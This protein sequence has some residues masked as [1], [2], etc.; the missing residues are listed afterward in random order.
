M[1]S[2]QVNVATT[3]IDVEAEL[4]AEKLRQREQVAST[5]ADEAKPVQAVVMADG[6][7]TF[8]EMHDEV[9][10]LT[11]SQLQAAIASA[12]EAALT[13]GTADLSAQL[14]QTTE[15]LTEAKS[16]VASLNQV[17]KVLGHPNP[18]TTSVSSTNPSGLAADFVAACEAAPAVVWIDSRTGQRHVQRDMSSAR[19]I[20]LVDRNQLRADMTAYA[21]KH[22]LLQ[23]PN[24]S[25]NAPTVRT[26]IPPAFL[27]FLSM[28]MRETHEARYVYW[29]FCYEK[30]ELGKGPG[31][32]I[33]VPR[34]RWLPEAAL[35]TDRHL[36]PGTNTNAN[37]QNLTAA[38]VSIALGERGLGKD[39]TFSPVAIPEFVMAYSMLQLENAV[40]EVLGHDYQ[41][42]E[43]LSI[44]S[45]YLATTRV[46]YNDRQSV[47]TVPGNVGAGDDGTFT[48]EF[49]NNLHAYMS[50]LLIPALDDGHYVLVV[51]DVGAAQIKN[52]LS[53]RNRAI[54]KMNF[55]YL[56]ELIQATTNREQGRTSGYAGTFCGFHIFTTNAHSMGAAGTEG[57]Q[58]ET[59]GVGATLTRSS[60]AFGRRAVARAQGMQAEI[61]QA[62]E[63][64][65]GR[66]QS[67]IWLS[68]EAI[69][70]LDVDPAIAAEQQL[71]VVEVR[72]LDRAV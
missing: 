14:A 40:M 68:H 22:G 1:A 33:Q 42:W 46:I 6:E 23:G 65:F 47:T 16:Q 61:R 36:A 44:R 4:Q 67:F 56:S 66:L 28:T 69:A 52:S 63:D 2:N 35:P 17:F 48:E 12:T 10:R 31:D 60:V 15:Q 64:D 13:R 9:I 21:R 45:R 39:S 32:T 7:K 71:R 70:D 29:Q 26:D 57:V 8:D 20:F 49:L 41:S 34:F 11:A 43:D 72:T 54:E 5:A 53:L 24:V 37:R 25:V 55:D 38:A 51:H 27:D 18:P 58:T 62:K 3:A 30:L 59:L 19:S 50:G